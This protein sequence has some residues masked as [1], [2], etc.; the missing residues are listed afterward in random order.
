[1]HPWKMVE[2][3][4][5]GGQHPWQVHNCRGGRERGEPLLGRPRDSVWAT[6]VSQ[7]LAVSLC[8]RRFFDL[9]GDPNGLHS[10]AY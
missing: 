1:M 8:T 5:Q 9:G 7:L 10:G 3:A 6:T 4:L 2:E